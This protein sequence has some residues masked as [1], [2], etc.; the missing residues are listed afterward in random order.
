MT[1]LDDALRAGRDLG[2]ARTVGGGECVRILSVH[3][4]K[5]LEFPVVF[6]CG[7][8]RRFNLTDSR[9]RVVWSE[10]LG[11][12]MKYYDPQS[13]TLYPTLFHAAAAE[14]ARQSA[15]EE[16]LRVLYVALTRARMNSW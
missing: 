14:S 6:L 5:G 16:E 8:G 9:R 12:C 3:R 2:S 15:I 4:S 7:A 10:S 11:V 1:Y 13:R